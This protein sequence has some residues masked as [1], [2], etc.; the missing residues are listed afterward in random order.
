M[1][2]TK[3]SEEVAVKNR[4]IYSILIIIV[5]LCVILGVSYAIFRYQKLG[6]KNNDVTTGT[7]ILELDDQQGTTISIGDAMPTADSKGKTSTPYTFT[8]RNTGTLNSKYRVKL[9]VDNE[10]IAKDKCGSNLLDAANIKLVLT[11]NNAMQTVTTYNALTDS[12]IDTG[13]INS[14]AH[15]DYQLRMWIDSTITNPALVNGKHFHVKVV[16]DAI[17]DKYMDFSDM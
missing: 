8:L 1:K 5:S 11:K 12:V 15:N 9:V 14:G 6:T 13:V 7:L 2:K 16:V 3:V 4:I 17:Q 10:A